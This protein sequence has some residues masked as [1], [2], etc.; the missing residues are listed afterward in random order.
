MLSRLAVHLALASLTFV[1][2]SLVASFD[3]AVTCIWIKCR[4]GLRSL[5]GCKD[6]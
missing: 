1:F 5:V 3:S 4:A 2:L 6:S